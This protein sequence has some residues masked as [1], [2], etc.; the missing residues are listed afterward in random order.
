MGREICPFSSM[1]YKQF[2]I[3]RLDPISPTFC[4][5]KWLNADFYLYNGTTS[6][7]NFPAP[8]KINFDQVSKN[9][10]RLH[11]TD[12]KIEQRRLMLNGEQPELCS[13]CWNIE[14]SDSEAITERV[15]FSQVFEQLD[16][17]KF[18]LSFDYK[19]KVVTVAFDTICNFTCSYCDA[20][21]STSWATDLKLNGPYK[22]IQGDPRNTY[23]RVGKSIDEVEY[24]KYFDYFKQYTVHCLD[25]L[26]ILTCLG[27]EPLSSPNF[28]NY[29]EFLLTLNTS[30]LT[31]RIVTN[32][33]NTKYLNYIIKHKHKFKEIQLF[34]S[35][36]GIGSR[37]EFIRN[38][39]KWEEFNAT[40]NDILSNT[41][42]K[43]SVLATIPGVACDGLIDFLN[44]YTA[45]CTKY[46]ENVTITLNRLRH[47]NFQSIEV[48]PLNLKD[49]YRK[50]L[51][52][53]INVNT[54]PEQTTEQVKNIII[55]LG[56]SDSPEVLQKSCKTFYKEYAKRH[57]FSI[58][59]IFSK[60]LSNWIIN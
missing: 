47:P 55:S 9:I 54:L 2:K 57:N 4:A 35:V 21:Q 1:N 31:L 49:I 18:D 40:V 30:N 26:D 52:D 3:T 45:L 60:E 25:E 36:D 33:S 44:W 51:I 58:E 6:S 42:I 59:E 38:G 11:N 43:I 32:L 56:S 50:E 34:V 13:N 15:I 10:D 8:H 53:W 22:N 12:E 41:N 17:N 29:F 46:K 23:I 14:N 20:S 19:P 28:K 24:Q 7:C 39:L 27:G 48:L 16:F 37:A 5:A